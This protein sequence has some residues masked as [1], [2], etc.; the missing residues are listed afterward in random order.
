M[1]R[2][3]QSRRASAISRSAGLPWATRPAAFQVTRRIP[4]SSMAMLATM[5][6]TACRWAIGS[7]NA[8]R[9]LT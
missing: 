7:P 9:S 1:P 6:A 5:K 8:S 4:C 2:S 3:E